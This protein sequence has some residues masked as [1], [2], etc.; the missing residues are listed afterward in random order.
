[1]KKVFAIFSFSF[2]S[3]GF[4][5][6]TPSLDLLNSLSSQILE[7]SIDKQQ[8]LLLLKNIFISC[9]ENN[10]NSETQRICQSFLDNSLSWL[11]TKYLEIISWEWSATP[12]QEKCFRIDYPN[13]PWNRITI[14]WWDDTTSISTGTEETINKALTGIIEAKMCHSYL[15][16]GTYNVSLD[17]SEQIIHL[18]IL[19]QN[20]SSFQINN[21]KNL[22]DLYLG[23]NPI[24]KLEN[25]VFKG[26]NQLET[27]YLW[28][29]ELA[30]IESEVF[31]DTKSLKFLN[32]WDNELVAIDTQWMQDLSQLTYLSIAENKINRLSPDIFSSLKY[33]EYLDI[34]GNP[35]WVLSRSYFQGLEYMSNIIEGEEITSYSPFK[36]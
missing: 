5:L 22:K 31:K 13:L 19:G 30:S 16:T 4:S 34:G 12:S 15:S 35:F 17:H 14:S 20:I 36:S 2:L 25:W 3:L 6:A 21:A 10:K 29:S 7:K 23:E 1:M 32:L 27:L 9:A 8:D 18:Q 33:L 28:K 24:K 26:L 11:E